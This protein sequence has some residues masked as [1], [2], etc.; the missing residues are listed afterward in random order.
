[1]E[2]RACHQHDRVPMRLLRAG[3]LRDHLPLAVAALPLAAHD[4]RDVA[5]LKRR[6]VLQA[7]AGRRGLQLGGVG[8]RI[9]ITLAPRC[10]RDGRT[11]GQRTRN[12]RADGQRSEPAMRIARIDF[13]MVVSSY[14]V[15]VAIRSQD[16]CRCRGG[17]WMSS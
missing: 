14:L 10:G 9:L 3:H 6:R 13:F 5:R 8:D 2:L 4:P 7:V 16:G 11:P 12:D 1:V 15:V 17:A